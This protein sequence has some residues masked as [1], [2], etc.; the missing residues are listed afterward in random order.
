M[1]AHFMGPALFM[2]VVVI[3]PL[4]ERASAA[5]LAVKIP[6]PPSTLMYSD[7]WVVAYGGR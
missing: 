5:K 6:I 7:T 4:W 1:V 2:P 3:N